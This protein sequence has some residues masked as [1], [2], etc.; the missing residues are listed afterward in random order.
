M[1]RSCLGNLLGFTISIPAAQATGNT[2]REMR[3][4]NGLRQIF[5]Q[6]LLLTGEEGL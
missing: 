6:N 2:R 4:R 5:I 3:I 1:V